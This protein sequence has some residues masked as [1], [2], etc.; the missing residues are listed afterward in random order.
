MRVLGCEMVQL[1]CARG[2]AVELSTAIVVMVASYS[3]LP[4]STTQT[5]TGAI[6]AVG[7]FEGIRGVNWKIAGKVG[8]VQLL[9]CRMMQF[10][11]DV[12]CSKL[13]SA[14]HFSPEKSFRNIL[15]LY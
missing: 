3:G 7:C 9:A 1:T 13:R 6:I 11:G 4:V 14:A 8:S 15:N 2:F 10:H 12:P 5:V